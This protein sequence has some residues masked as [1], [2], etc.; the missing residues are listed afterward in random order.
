MFIEK[1][2]N[3]YN[4][5][6]DETDNDFCITGSAAIYYYLYAIASSN[7]YI[8]MDKFKPKDV[9]FLIKVERRGSNENIK[10]I[11]SYVRTDLLQERVTT[12]VDRDTNETI[13]VILQNSLSFYTINKDEIKINLLTPTALLSDYLDNIREN[14]LI[15]IEALQYIEKYLSEYNLPCISKNKK[16]L[17]KREEYE[18]PPFEPHIK[19][20]LFSD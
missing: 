16:V 2:Q 18:L 10:N 20:S 6:S 12:Y 8:F 7:A 9:D 1:I 4:K 5:L 11:G 13:N 19:K 3:I 14:D 17:R 15:K